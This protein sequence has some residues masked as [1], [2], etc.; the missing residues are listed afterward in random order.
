MK[1]I[2]I[3]E[4]LKLQLDILKRVD[5]FCRD[6]S[7]SYTVFG[8][9]CIGA[10]RHKGYIPW[11]DDIDIA[12][13]RP[14]YD[15]FIHSFNGAF[16]NLEVLAPELDWD[17]YAPFANVHDKRT[18]LFEGSNG[19]HGIELGVKIDVFP[20]DGVSSN[21]DEYHVQKTK[22]AKLWSL[23]YSKRVVISQLWKQNHR[24][25]VLCFIKRIVSL[26]YSYARVQKRIHALIVKSPY[27]ESEYV[28]LSCYPWPNDSRCKRDVFDEYIS[29]PFESLMV[30]IIKD[31]D[32]Y[33]RKAYGDYMQLP[34]EKD[35][36]PKHSFSAYW[37]D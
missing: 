10:V 17:Y 31:Y 18:I 20:I 30:S 9:T 24:M 12:M 4:L 11:D 1:E 28:D 8:G 32:I 25:A 22:F 27:Q 15:R 33:L 13:T 7:I 36:I 2:L 21:D 23:L 26:G 16:E 5:E 34:P 6:N 3:D 29:I 37:K 35:R 14:E 19:H